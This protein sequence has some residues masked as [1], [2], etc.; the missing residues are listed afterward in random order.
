VNVARIVSV[1]MNKCDPIQV[2]FAIPAR[3]EQMYPGELAEIL[4]KW[5]WQRYKQIE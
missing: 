5:I 2:G 3:V 4:S 1:R